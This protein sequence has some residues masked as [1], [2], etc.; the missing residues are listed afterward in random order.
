MRPS[1]FES[2]LLT[3][4]VLIVTLASAWAVLITVAKLL[5]DLS[6]ALA[7]VIR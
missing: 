3:L 5:A 7:A 6:G 4:V 1:L 2:P